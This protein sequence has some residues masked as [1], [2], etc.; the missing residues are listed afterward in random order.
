MEAIMHR[1]LMA[2]LFTVLALSAA[3]AEDTSVSVITAPDEPATNEI[4]LTPDFTGGVGAQ[5]DPAGGSMIIQLLP[6]SDTGI[7]NAPSNF[8]YVRATGH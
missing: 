6:A 7:S 3:R 4:S 1:S 8:H 5:A 2:A